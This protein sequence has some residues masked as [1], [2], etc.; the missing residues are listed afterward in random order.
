MKYLII[1]L[2]FFINVQ[3]QSLSG[4]AV[5]KASID[6]ESYK[7]EQNQLLKKN[8]KFS[9]LI[10]LNLK[11]TRDVYYELIFNNNRSQFNSISALDPENLKGINYTKILGGSGE[12]YTSLNPYLILSK[13]NHFPDYLIE[14]KPLVWKLIDEKREISGYSCY[15]AITEMQIENSSNRKNIKITAWY[16]PEIPTSFGPKIFS[17]LP[18]LVV[19]LIDERGLTFEMT[20]FSNRKIKVKEF[21]EP[22][23]KLISNE[24]FQLKIMKLMKRNKKN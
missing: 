20:K 14:E 17:G 23:G 18:G 4:R 13:N 15:K 19:Y 10:E 22:K 3:S 11:A 7:K 24:E 6:F 16:A 1:F 12:I 8:S 2:L 9:Q 21:T 5:Y